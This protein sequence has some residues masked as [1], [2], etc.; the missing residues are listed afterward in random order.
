MALWSVADPNNIGT[1][2]Q[3]SQFQLLLRLV[4]MAQAGLLPLNTT[5]DQMQTMLLQYSSRQLAL[6]IFSSV[7]VLPQ[8]QLMN[9]YG[10]FIVVHTP[11]A[12]QQTP[13]SA[14]NQGGFWSLTSYDS[15]TLVSPPATPSPSDF[16]TITG[17]LGV[18][19]FTQQTAT[20]SSSSFG[21]QQ[22]HSPTPHR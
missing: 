18:S 14:S 11:N 15:P 3:M 13:S 6:P 20:P 4:S 22:Q 12:A 17:S 16:G 1:L 2:T 5:M 19:S 8:D 21:Q 7:V 9:M 10:S